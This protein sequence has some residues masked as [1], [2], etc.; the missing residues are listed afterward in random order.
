MPQTHVAREAIALRQLLPRWREGEEGEGGRSRSLISQF[1]T[2]L[3]FLLSP[4]SSPKD[5]ESDESAN[6]L[7]EEAI[8]AS[9][10]IVRKKSTREPVCDTGS[11]GMLHILVQH[12]HPSLP[13]RW[14]CPSTPILEPLWTNRRHSTSRSST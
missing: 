1:L 10:K 5:V 9:R 12:H 8:E 11:A 3:P 4:S 6:D 14:F 7:R 13:L 2:P